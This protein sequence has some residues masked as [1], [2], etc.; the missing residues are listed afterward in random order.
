MSMEMKDSLNRKK[1]SRGYRN[2]QLST[3]LSGIL[4][5]TTLVLF[6]ILNVVVVLAA[7]TALSREKVNGLF[8]IANANVEKLTQTLHVNESIA[9]N[10]DNSL[11][12]MYEQKDYSEIFMSNPYSRVVP[13]QRITEIRFQEE[14]LILNTLHSALQQ[15]EDMVGIGVFF[16]KNAFQSSVENYAPYVSRTD[17]AAGIVENMDYASYGGQDNY[18]KTAAESGKPVYTDPV[19]REELGE[20]IITAAYPV[21]YGG[22]FVGAV[23]VDLKTELFAKLDA[24]QGTQYRSLF[25]DII[26]PRDLIVSSST[27]SVILKKI[28]DY[29]SPK[30]YNAAKEKMQAGEQF[31]LRMDKY[32]RC[33]T[34][35][36]M[37][38]ENWWT[39]VYIERAEFEADKVRLF[40]VLTAAE[41][42]IL[43][44]ILLLTFFILR[45]SLRPLRQVSGVADRVAEGDLDVSL[46][47]PYQDDIGKLVSSINGMLSRVKEIIGNLDG[48]LRELAEGNYA[49]DNYQEIDLY[50]GSYRPLLNSLEDITHGLNKTMSGIRE[51]SKQVN[52]GAGQVSVGAQAL[53]QGAMEQASSV[54]ELS[55]NLNSISER[56]RE[57]ARMAQQASGLSETAGEAVHIS[58]DKME[59][60]SRA[61]R[62]ITEKSNEIGKIIKTID[63]I[64]FQTNILSLNA[65]IEAARAGAAGKGFAVVAD[66]VGNLAQKSA[67]AAQNTSA[68]IEETLEAIHRGAKITEET[69][70]ALSSVSRGTKEVNGIIRRISEASKEEAK[71]ITQFT[72][73][74]DQISSVV[75]TNSATAEESAAA[76]EEMARQAKN[77][78][79]LVS[80]FRLREKYNEDKAEKAEKLENEALGPEEETAA[81][82]T[83]S[84]GKLVKCAAKSAEKP[85]CAP[86]DLSKI[87]EE[88]IRPFTEPYEETEK[89]E[90]TYMEAAR[91]PLMKDFKFDDSKY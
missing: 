47:Y 90:D 80:V 44:I 56:I 55:T 5:G 71:G 24:G 70:E 72:E 68:L 36:E 81:E 59:E 57:T 29:M 33:L 91:E 14:Q 82:E 35:V 11:Q 21:F 18:F 83:K 87:P 28:S 63:D 8:S 76:S 7:S 50:I 74:L 10:L 79:D 19:F 54:E 43:L 85:S 64:A 40:W 37:G 27:E 15:N 66:E 25:F 86:L 4:G 38:G 32:V 52:I 48:K 26:S 69:A 88:E 73:G 78:N 3:R 20:N 77:L 9:K 12:E 58:N 30:V 61:M 53:S 16:E 23:V 67:K 62:D 75:Q 46:D 42:S 60:L 84:A 2:W 22:K 13:E 65:A 51:A 49:L 39:Q 31:E 41:I 34:P 17:D 6:I 1:R 45:K 89:E